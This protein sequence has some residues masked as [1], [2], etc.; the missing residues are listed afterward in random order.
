MKGGRCEASTVAWVCRY[1]TVCFIFSNNILILALCT[2]GCGGSQR[3]HPGHQ[4][5]HQQDHGLYFRQVLHVRQRLET[6]THT[7]TLHPLPAT[8]RQPFEQIHTNPTNIHVQTHSSATHTLAH[9][10]THLLLQVL[11]SAV[12]VSYLPVLVQCVRFNFVCRHER[13]LPSG[14][15]LHV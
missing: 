15:H 8:R 14:I 5:Q 7:A 11:H 12:A 13:N 9:V 4:S 2:C 3:M 1:T 6:H 10:P